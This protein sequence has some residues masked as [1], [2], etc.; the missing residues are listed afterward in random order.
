MARVQVGYDPTPEGVR[1]YTG[2]QMQAAQARNDP[3]ANVSPL[4]QSLAQINP[5]LIQ[6][7][8]QN[9]NETFVAPERDEATKYANSMTLDELGKK[10]K[11][12]EMLPSQ[13]PVF[14][15]TVENIYGYNTMQMF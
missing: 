5:G 2:P 11:S 13:S 15:A 4:V 7:T 1:V 6:Q 9:A 12:G 14:R 3:L 8:M 10:L